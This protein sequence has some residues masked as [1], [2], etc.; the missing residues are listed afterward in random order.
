MTGPEDPTREQP[1]VEQPTVSTA[2]PPTPARPHRW[3]SVIPHHL[4]RARTSTVVISLLFVALFVLYLNVRPDPE[5]G[6]GTTSGGTDVTEPAPTT[7]G[8][9]TTP[10]APTT[11]PAS[12]TVEEPTTTEGTTPTVPEDTTVPSEPTG[13]VPSP[14]TETETVP[15]LPT[16]SE[17][18]G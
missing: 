8:T 9:T 15:P 4:G 17:P 11:T 10:P 2:P 1:V 13:T 18:T 12:P 3:W 6:A 14:E 7:G 5:A 16:T